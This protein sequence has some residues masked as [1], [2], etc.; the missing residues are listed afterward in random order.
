MFSP[1]SLLPRSREQMKSKF[2]VT[3]YFLLL[4][5]FVFMGTGCGKK[6]AESV[7]VTMPQKNLLDESV[8][9]EQLPVPKNQNLLTGKGDLSQEAIGKRPVAV[10]IN[11]VEDALPQYGIAQ[12]DIIFELPVEGDLTRLMALYADYTKVPDICAIRSCRYY[13]PAIAKGFDAFYVHWGMD[14]TV[15]GYV[16]SLKM[17]RYDGLSNDGKLFGRDKARRSSGYALEHTGYFK[18]TQFASV[19][20]NK[21]ERLELLNSKKEAAFQFVD[22]GQLV[23]PTGDACNT[24][25]IRFGA[26]N[27]K[28]T[29]NAETKTYDKF[30]NGHRHIDGK[31][32][33]QLTFTNVFVLETSISVRD[34]VGHKNLNWQGSSS[35]KGYYI[36]NGVVQTIRWF[37]SNEGSY[38]KFYDENGKELTINRGKSYIAYT[39][40]GRTTFDSEK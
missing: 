22:Y 35:S 5:M 36:S 6:E 8:Q 28:F 17:D 3:G 15:K 21:G 18:G 10:M 14:Q 27:S 26:C 25:A 1:H 33:Q 29:Y 40:K 4:C 32:G 11:N 38:L 16:A 9:L 31:T 23:K 30:M 20:Q 24:V 2:R 37:Q 39:Y 19:A 13:Y 12:A 7:Q 34:S